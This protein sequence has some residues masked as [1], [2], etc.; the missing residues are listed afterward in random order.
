M[1][2]VVELILPRADRS[3]GPHGLGAVHAVDLLCT[4]SRRACLAKK[5]IFLGAV[6]ARGG[7]STYYINRY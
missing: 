2:V 3:T 6:A 1:S 5:Q 7:L 4:G